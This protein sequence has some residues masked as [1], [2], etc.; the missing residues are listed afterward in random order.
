MVNS[1]LINSVLIIAGLGI[2][3]V[4]TGVT[5]VQTA[6]FAGPAE[7]GGFAGFNIVGVAAGIV[8]L[9]VGLVLAAGEGK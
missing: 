4:S 5:G 3:I 1:E 2:A 6:A 7:I 9:L 8:V